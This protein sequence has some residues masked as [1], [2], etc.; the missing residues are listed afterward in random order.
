MIRFVA[1]VVL[2]LLASG[3]ANESNRLPSLFI[4]EWCLLKNLDEG[5]LYILGDCSNGGGIATMKVQSDS[6]MFDE[7]YIK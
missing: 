6:T 4:A 7:A 3:F 2:L 1:L 5:S